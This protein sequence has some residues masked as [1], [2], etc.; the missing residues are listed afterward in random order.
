MSTR[1]D[2]LDPT[3]PLVVLSHGM[4]QDSAAMLAAFTDEAQP[5]IRAKYIGDAAQLLVIHADTGA[6]HEETVRYRDWVRSYCELKGIVYFQVDRD[7][8]F[9]SGDWVGGLQAQWDASNTI[10][11]VAFPSTCSDRLKI[12]PIWHAVNRILADSFGVSPKRKNG[13]YEHTR[14]FGRKIRSYLGIAKG[15]ERRLDAVTRARLELRLFDELVEAPGIG[16]PWFDRNAVHQYPLI[17]L[18]I[19][20]AGAQAYLRSRNH[21]VPRPSLCRF[22]HWKS[23]AEL[24]HMARTL[25]DD[26]SYWLAAEERKMTLNAGSGQNHGVK[27]AQTLR[28]FLAEAEAE[29][30]H[31]STDEL[32]GYVMTHGH[33][34][35]NVRQGAA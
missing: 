9:H 29:Y 7:L 30:G 23:K 22:C 1:Y 4:G 35:F 21:V 13:M 34:M 19:D 10:G 18:G 16:D 14:R 11:S 3:R 12:Q 33:C 27:G 26:L 32:Y 5:E 24:V 31:L 8:G 17:D 25:P 2:L 20:R 6:E 28:S 15:E